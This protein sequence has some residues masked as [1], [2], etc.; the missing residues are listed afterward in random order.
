MNRYLLTP[1]I[2]CAL[3]YVGSAAENADHP[4]KHHN[5][6]A[7]DAPTSTSA[8]VTL[9]TIDP[10]SGLAT[11]TKIEAVLVTAA[12]DGKPV[13]MKIATANAMDA[14]KVR[15]AS[16]ADKALYIKAAQTNGMVKDG[17]VVPVPKM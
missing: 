10:V 7:A 12:V 11:D 5:D 15:S 3:S 4:H 17:K 13:T 8:P 9:N 2:L 14:S 6:P 1:A 16:A